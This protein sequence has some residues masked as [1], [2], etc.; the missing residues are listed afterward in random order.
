MSSIMAD[1]KELNFL[2]GD[3]KAGTIYL[4]NI[5][6]GLAPDQ[7]DIED[8]ESVASEPEPVNPDD[9]SDT[10]NSSAPAE[11]PNTDTAATALPIALLLVMGLALSVI[12]VVIH[13][14]RKSV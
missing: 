5:R 1:V 13:R 7:E 11:E 3:D 12:S 2:F 8:N 9:A 6:F 4:D 14:K 10:G